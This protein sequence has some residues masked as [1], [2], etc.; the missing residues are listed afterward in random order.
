MK[1]KLFRFISFILLFIFLLKTGIC[2]EKDITITS[3]IIKVN[4]GLKGNTTFF[5]DIT[6][7]ITIKNNK[8]SL[9]TDNLVFYIGSGQ[10]VKAKAIVNEIQTNLSFTLKDEIVEIQ[11]EDG[12]YINPNKSIEIILEYRIYFTGPEEKKEFRKK[13]MNPHDEKVTYFM[14]NPVKSLGFKPNLNG[15]DSI[16]SKQPGWYVSHLVSPEIGD[17]LVFSIRKSKEYIPKP[18][19]LFAETHLVNINQKIS[20]DNPMHLEITEVIVLNNTAET[21]FEG[22]LPFWVSDFAKDI[23]IIGIKQNENQEPTKVRLEVS[24]INQGLVYTKFESEMKLLPNNKREVIL[25]Y[26]VPFPTVENVTWDKK[27][28]YEHANFEIILNPITQ[29]GY[30]PDITNQDKFVIQEN[31]GRFSYKLTEPKKDQIFS[32]SIIKGPIPPPPLKQRLKNLNNELNQEIINNPFLFIFLNN[33]VLLFFI[34]LELWFILHLKNEP[35][36]TKV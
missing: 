23:T 1:L 7:E 8:D 14:T 17:T 30:K 11:L 33:I 5:Y 28:T 9:F 36:H 24:N 15:I 35:P 6:E 16:E 34:G 18:S 12:F 25:L 4:Q 3:H 31:Q 2:N 21:A 22:L 19:D 32:I 29:Y 27:I 26:Y 20:E 10:E 13:I